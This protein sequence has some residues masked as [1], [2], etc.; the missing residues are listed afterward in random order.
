MGPGFKEGVIVAL[1]VED[2]APSIAQVD[3]M[4]TDSAG[5]GSCSAWHKKR[6]YW[7]AAQT[8]IVNVSVPLSSR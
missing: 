6:P 1:L 4:V 2:L 3:D 5:K 8:S 7:P